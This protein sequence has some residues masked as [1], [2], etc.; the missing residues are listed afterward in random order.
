MG[1][2]RTRIALGALGVLLLSLSPLTASAVESDGFADGDSVTVT[3][4]EADKAA[5]AAD[6]VPPAVR[7][8]EY[9]HADGCLLGVP[10]SG[11]SPG[12]CTPPE[13]PL[14]RPDCDDLAPIEPLWR[15]TRTTTSDGWSGW[16]Y[17]LGW[18]CP[19]DVLPAFT[20]ADFRRLPLAPPTIR[21]QPDTGRVLVNLPLIT[22]TDATPQ[23]LVTDL[24]GYDVEVDATPISYSWDYGDGSASLVT[25]S[26]GHPYPGHDVSHAYARAGSFRVTLTVTYSGRYRLAGTTAWLPVVG[27]ATTTATSSPIVAEEAPSHLVATDCTDD[28]RPAGC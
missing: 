22:M 17:V 16:R 11:A 10:P 8:V 14:P 27:T 23:L 28:P 3:A 7:L 6:A 9:M 4:R 5:R 21:V 2:W 18:S 12:P 15:R 26:T 20:A 1:V 25:T 19:Q 24:L 13:F